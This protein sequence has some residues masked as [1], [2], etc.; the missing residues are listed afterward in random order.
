[1]SLNRGTSRT[2]ASLVVVAVILGAT[3]LSAQQRRTGLVMATP[4]QLRGVPLASLP[5]SGEELPPFVDLA[6]NLPPPGDQGEQ[7]SCVGWTVAYALKSYQENLE[8][9]WGLVAGNGQLDPNRIFS[10]AFVYNQINNGRD[11]GSL[12]IDALNLMASTG[13][14]T[15][16][17]MPYVPDDYSRKPP[18]AAM[19]AASRFRIDYWRQV[20]VKDLKEVKAQLNA[21][22]PVMIGATIDEGFVN[23]QSGYVW[24]ETLGESLGGHAMLLVGYDDQRQSIKLINSWGHEWGDGGYGWIDYEHFPRVVNEGYVAKD[25]LNRDPRTPTTPTT[26]PTTP[27]D[28]DPTPTDWTQPQQTASF[29][30]TN[31][32]HNT[33]Y[34]DRPDLGYFM[35]FDGDLS[36][37]AG[38]GSSFQVVIHFYFDNGDGTKGEQVPS[39]DAQ[40][41]DPNGFAACGTAAYA[42]EPQ[43]NEGT[44]YAFIPYEALALPDAGGGG[45]F[46][47][48]LQDAVSGGGDAAGPFAMLAEPVLFVDNFGVA[49]GE[50]VPFVVGN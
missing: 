37:P 23:A 48:R 21:G 15:W 40:Y 27:T 28:L 18:A 29:Q 13:V 44:W 50:L 1:M 41:S 7:N 43:G 49:A 12:F 33:S 4:E 3:A 46:Q 20:N 25:A 35:R 26:T 22:Y 24:R 19:Q 5:Y 16:A 30:I 45:D 8:E 31:V 32:T 10:P 11:G 34:E 42:V 47:S 9:R 6:P 2:L 38:M 17:D 14:A 36:I 39:L